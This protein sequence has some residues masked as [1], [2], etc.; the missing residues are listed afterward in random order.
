MPTGA[1]L[2]APRRP[3]VRGLPLLALIAALVLTAWIVLSFARTLAAINDSAER[4][5]ALRAETAALEMRVAQGQAENELAQQPA[6]QRMLARSH[7]MGLPGERAFALEAGA[8]EPPAVVPLGGA[9]GAGAVAPI[10]AWL[11]LLIGD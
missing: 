6:F 2:A 3:R 5:A 11:A 1:V 8:P 4:A 9:E 7:G 10:D